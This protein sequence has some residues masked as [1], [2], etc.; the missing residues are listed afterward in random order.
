MPPRVQNDEDEPGPYE[1]L[2]PSILAQVEREHVTDR[3]AVAQLCMP[4][5]SGEGN[6]A[7][8]LRRNYIVGYRAWLGANA[9]IQKAALK[10]ADP[11]QKQPPFIRN[12]VEKG[13]KP[14][15]LKN[16]NVRERL[17][18]VVKRA[19][20]HPAAEKLVGARVFG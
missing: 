7:T 19:Y 11:K 3:N 13:H 20:Q 6:T 4:P 12:T 14:D 10:L 2:L 16:P 5:A 1:V 8:G 9:A 17:K 15:V 18:M